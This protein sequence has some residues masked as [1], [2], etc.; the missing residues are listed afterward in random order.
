MPCYQFA[1]LD[2]ETSFELKRPFAQASDPATCPTCDS[3]H[4]QKQLNAI[5]FQTSSISVPM[6]NQGCGGGCACQHH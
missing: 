4:T 3:P 1:C 6:R 2:C 5:A